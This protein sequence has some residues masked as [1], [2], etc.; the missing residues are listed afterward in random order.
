MSNTYKF[1]QVVAVIFDLDGVIVDNMGYHRKAWG[2]FLEK[3][4]PKINLA[5]FSRHFGKTNQELLRLIFKRDIS[6]AEAADW[7]DE[8]EAIY[9]RIYTS[10]I[11]PLPGLIEL[12]QDMKKA[13]IRLAVASAA[14]K[15]NVDFVL[16]RISLRGFFDAVLDASHSV[17]GKPDP[18]IYL[19]A[20]RILDVPP[21]RCLVFED[22]LPGVQAARNAGMTVVGVTTTYSAEMLKDIDGAIKDFTG[23]NAASIF[24]LLDRR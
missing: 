4:A 1:S 7:G 13:G 6:K 16:E 2:L 22:S 21:D 20:A 24:R 3:Y 15:I 18:G 17:K 10:S 11:H 9:R 14:P 5:D 19:N 8:K 12:L 23:L